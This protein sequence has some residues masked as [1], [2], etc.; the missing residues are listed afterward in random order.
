MW[1]ERGCSTFSYFNSVHVTLPAAQAT[2]KLTLR[3]WSVVH[4]VSYDPRR[5]KASGVRVIDAQTMQPLEF[6][7]RVIFLCA[8]A[9]E[10]AR[11]LLNSRTERWPDGLANSSGALG[12][13]LMDHWMGWGAHGDVPADESRTTFGSRPNGTYLPRFRNVTDQTPGFLR[14]YGYQEISPRNGEGKLLGGRSY[15]AASAEARIGITETIGLVP[16]VDVGTVSTDEVPDFKDIRA[17]AGIGLRYATPFGPLR[18]DVAYNPYRLQSG[19]LFQF[20]ENGDLTPV[21]GQSNYVLD[22]EGHITY[23]FAVGQPF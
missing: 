5:G 18:L 17:G 22:R 19:P 6:N 9:L 10:S 13:Y 2:R 20:D 12:R 16:F 11:I 14:G 7:A 8:S 23:H 1:C 15:V 21:T 3:P 4:S